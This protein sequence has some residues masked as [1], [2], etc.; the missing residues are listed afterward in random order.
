MKLSCY[1]VSPVPILAVNIIAEIPVVEDE[2]ETETET[3]EELKPTSTADDPPNMDGYTR[4]L[5]EESCEASAV[6]SVTDPPNLDGSTRQLNEEPCGTSAVDSVTDLDIDVHRSK[7]RWDEAELGAFNREF[8]QYIVDKKMAP[9]KI[10]LKVQKDD[11][12]SRSVAQ[13]RTRLNNVILGKQKIY[14]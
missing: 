13:I 6:V 11:L 7:R 1:N 4:K 14:P 8:K 2:E 3:T 10:I 12:P 9:G 5:D